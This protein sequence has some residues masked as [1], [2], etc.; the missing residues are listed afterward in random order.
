MIATAIVNGLFLIFS[1]DSGGHSAEDSC[2][3]TYA[4]LD[5]LLIPSLLGRKKVVL[6]L[7]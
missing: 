3:G 7:S 4:Y 1:A 2:A 6:V 5:L